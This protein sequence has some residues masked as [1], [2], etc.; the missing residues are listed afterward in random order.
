M[1]LWNQCIFRSPHCLTYLLFGM[2]IINLGHILGHQSIYQRKSQFEFS[3]PKAQIF[4]TFEFSAKIESSSNPYFGAKIQILIIFS[5]FLVDLKLFDGKI[6][7]LTF[8]QFFQWRYLALFGTPPCKVITTAVVF[9]VRLEFRSGS[10]L[11]WP[12]H[13]ESPL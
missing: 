6:Q 9:H 4:Q 2:Q 1:L 12:L 8:F 11:N 13:L 7:N 3:R 5:G 10:L